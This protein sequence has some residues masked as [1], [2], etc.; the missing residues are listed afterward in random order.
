MWTKNADGSDVLRTLKESKVGAISLARLATPF[1]I[2][3]SAN[4]QLGQVRSSGVY[5][6]DDGQVGTVQQ[7]DLAV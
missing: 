4:A 1:A 6:S 2:K 5:L 7:V 3:D